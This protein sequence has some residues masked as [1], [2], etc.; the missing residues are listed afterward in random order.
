MPCT[1]PLQFAC[2][3]TCADNQQGYHQQR[4]TMF[5]EALQ[6][7]LLVLFRYLTPPRRS[8]HSAR[9]WCSKQ[10]TVG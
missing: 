10:M 5:D 8:Q 4:H 7:V 6:L 9:T 1:P 3:M 2:G